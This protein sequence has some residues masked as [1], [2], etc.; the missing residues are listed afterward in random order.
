[1]RMRDVTIDSV[2]WK[3]SIS[4]DFVKTNNLN[5]SGFPPFSRVHDPMGNYVSISHDCIF[6][7]SAL[8]TVATDSVFLFSL[9]VSFLMS[10]VNTY[11]KQIPIIRVLE[12]V[13]VG[14]TV[15]VMYRCRDIANHQTNLS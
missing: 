12:N 3:S 2:N 8:V 4:S 11:V 9:F 10:V 7:R 13:I 6:Q 14:K 5:N 15:T 1:M